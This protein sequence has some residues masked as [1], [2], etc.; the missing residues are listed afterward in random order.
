VRVSLLLFV[1]LITSAISLVTA[2]HDTRKLVSE[3]EVER[4]KAALIER[5]HTELVTEKA[6]LTS[7]SR[8]ERL[9]IQKLK[10]KYPKRE[11]IVLLPPPPA[12]A[13]Q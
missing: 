3:I 9:A 8:I 2:R 6:T 5:H 12:R 4:N 1:L 10:M 11:D 7:P 13:K